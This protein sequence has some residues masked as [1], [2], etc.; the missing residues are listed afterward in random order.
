MASAGCGRE[1]RAAPL[2]AAA[3]PGSGGARPWLPAP[4][5]RPTAQA[6]GVWR[7]HGHAQLSNHIVISTVS[8]RGRKVLSHYHRFCERFREAGRRYVPGRMRGEVEQGGGAGMGGP[9]PTVFVPNGHGCSYAQ[10]A[11]GAAG[12]RGHRDGRRHG[13]ETLPSG[14]N[15]ARLRVGALARFRAEGA[16]YRWWGAPRH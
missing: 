8:P 11:P 9:V 15:F 3:T 6:S 14:T 13:G 1:A 7:S 5:L 2:S 16:L 4:A 12:R 10:P